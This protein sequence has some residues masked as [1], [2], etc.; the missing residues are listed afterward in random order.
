[1][2]E[3]V[4]CKVETADQC[5]DRTGSRIQ[6]DKSTFNFRKLCDLP[7][8]FDGFGNS[9][10]RAS[11]D[12][13]VRTR[14]VGKTRLGRAQALSANFDRFAALAHDKDTFG[15]GFKHD[16]GHDVSVV[17][18]VAQCIVD[19][20][21]DFER[22]RRH[23]DELFR[24]AINLSSFKIH[25]ALAQCLVRDSLV[26]SQQSGVDVDTTRIGVFTVLVVDKL[27]D[28]FRDVLRVYAP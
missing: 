27:A 21:F 6:R 18:T 12:L 20:V 2:V 10:Q 14:L 5:S 26:R 8:I 11:P 13:D 23:V 15:I 17:R 19:C 7:S 1:M 3:L 24:P 4:F 28:R 25:D 16:R 9:D 22:I